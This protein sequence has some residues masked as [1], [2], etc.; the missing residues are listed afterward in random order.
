VIVTA[1]A[2]ALTLRLRYDFRSVID[3]EDR[4]NGNTLIFLTRFDR[5][6]KAA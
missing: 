6:L 1:P 5:V 4:I 2:E 3:G